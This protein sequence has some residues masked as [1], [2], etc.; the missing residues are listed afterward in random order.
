MLFVSELGK[1]ST[2]PKA[3]DL[4]KYSVPGSRH[5][6]QFL[7]YNFSAQNHKIL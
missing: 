2:A 5:F 4:K 1:V 3:C 6:V 7:S